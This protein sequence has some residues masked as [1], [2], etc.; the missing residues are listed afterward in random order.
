MP[1]RAAARYARVLM[2]YII[3]FILGIIFLAVLITSLVGMGQRRGQNGTLPSDHPVSR[4]E[5]AADEANP[6][7]S[8]TATPRQRENAE[9]HTP[10]S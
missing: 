5:P 6:A 7:A 8:A 1:R 3:V 10:P 2:G 4:T 9:R